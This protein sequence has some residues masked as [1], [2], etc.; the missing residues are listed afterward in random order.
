MDKQSSNTTL[1]Y[2]YAK[3]GIMRMTRATSG[4]GK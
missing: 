3:V 2:P 4:A 1:I